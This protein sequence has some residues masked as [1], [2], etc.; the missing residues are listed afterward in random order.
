MKK[1]C[2]VCALL[3][4]LCLCAG[5]ASERGVAES[6]PLPEASVPA[7]ESVLLTE[8]AAPAESSSFDGLVAPRQMVNH[9]FLSE[10]N[11][12][13]EFTIR[14][15]LRHS[16]EKG[17]Y[18]IENESSKSRVTFN[19]QVPDALSA[20]FES[21]TGKKVTVNGTLTEVQSTWTK[22]LLVTEI[23]E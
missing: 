11:I 22:T 5:C 6:A 20:Q 23:G 14:G 12:G 15:V 2:C 16:A 7:A 18:L 3:T 9:S 4:M 21:L 10:E 17:F 13:Q 8:A 1:A 19:L